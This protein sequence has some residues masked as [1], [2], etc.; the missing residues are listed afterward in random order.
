LPAHARL[1]RSTTTRPEKKVEIE[2]TA[3]TLAIRA[4][5]GNRMMLGFELADGRD[6]EPAIEK[7]IAHPNAEYLH[8]HFA[9]SGCY[10][11]RVERA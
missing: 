11:A 9:A 7:L 5:D 4:F 3:R 6:L 10:A 2:V 1:H 8:V